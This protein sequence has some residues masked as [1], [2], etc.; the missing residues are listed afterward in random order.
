MIPRAR[1]C[2]LVSVKTGEMKIWNFLLLY[3]L[4]ETHKVWD[5]LVQE[6]AQRPGNQK[7]CQMSNI[8]DFYNYEF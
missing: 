1:A 4:T 3:P 6:G 7:E 5:S 2:G 8:T